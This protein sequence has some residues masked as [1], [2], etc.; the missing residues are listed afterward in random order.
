[1][2]ET[3]K[4]VAHMLGGRMTKG[5]TQD[6]APNRDLFHLLP[7]DGSPSETIQCSDV[8]A[9]YFVK[10]FEGDPRR[11]DLRGFIER[12]D[13]LAR[14]NKVAVRFKD[15]ELLCGY[16]LSYT[17]ERAGF[18]L[19]PADPGTNNLRIY[20]VRSS[21]LAVKSGPAAE[22]MARQALESAA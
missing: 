21:T 14:G 13:A 2:S 11:V 18:F 4:V 7:A 12:K 5:T 3:N 15:G 19:L 20:V 16:A 9:V 8:K 1:M 22:M 6:F 10:D 17:A